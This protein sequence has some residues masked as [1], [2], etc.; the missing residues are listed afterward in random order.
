MSI[1]I[2]DAMKKCNFNLLDRLNSQQATKQVF[3]SF[4]ILFLSAFCPSLQASM[5]FDFQEFTDSNNDYGGT[6]VEVSWSGSLNVEGLTRRDLSGNRVFLRANENVGS[7][8]PK[9]FVWVATDN[10]PGFS[11]WTATGLRASDASEG[12]IIPDPIFDPQGRPQISFF[13]GSPGKDPSSSEDYIVTGDAI[14]FSQ[15]IFSD[16]SDPAYEIF[17][18]YDYISGETIT[19]SVFFRNRGFSDLYLPSSFE[20]SFNFGPDTITYRVVPE[21]STYGLLFG[22]L[23]FVAMCFKK[24]KQLKV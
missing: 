8:D 16:G 1:F 22:G 15:S 12:A 21:P 11:G 14:G 23:I 24:R 13:S 4:S 2:F 10:E 5:T 7:S 17:T 6:G 9:I 19:G 3:V 20:T 18:P